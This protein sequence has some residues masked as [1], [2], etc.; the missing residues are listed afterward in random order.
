MAGL[1]AGKSAA[2]TGGV[3]GI[4]R[5]IALGFL[6]Q[7]ASVTVNHIDDAR[8][9]EHFESLKAEAGDKSARLVSVAGDIGKRETGQRIVSSALRAFGSLDVFVANAGV[10]QFRDFLT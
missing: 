5:A 8:S 3:T 1:L 7:G 4:G 6:Q 10:S 9:R 2:I